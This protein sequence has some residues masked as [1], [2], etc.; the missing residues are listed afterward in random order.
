MWIIIAALALQGC[1]LGVDK[2]E[3]DTV[4]VITLGSDS[5]SG[6]IDNDGEKYTLYVETEGKTFDLKGDLEEL[7]VLGNENYI[8]IL[9][10]TQINKLVIQGETNTVTIQEGLETDLLE[11]SITGNTNTVEVTTLSDTEPSVN[12]TGNVYPGS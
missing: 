12:G 9:E 8:L 5:T 6:E 11:L 3:D 10:D 2:E 7:R 4:D 1:K